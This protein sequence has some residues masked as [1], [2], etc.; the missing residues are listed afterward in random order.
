ME[1]SLLLKV[2][3]PLLGLG[4]ATTLLSSLFLAFIISSNAGGVITGII[5]LVLA[6]ALCFFAFFKNDNNRLKAILI[7]VVVFDLIGGFTAMS[8]EDKFHE[9]TGVLNKSMIHFI[10]LVGMMG[11]LCWFWHY[12]TAFMAAGHFDAAG[13]DLGQETMLY[14]CWSLLVAF[15]LA[16]ATGNK[17]SYYKDVLVKTCIVNSIGFWFLGA[18]LSGLLGLWIAFKSDSGDGGAVASPLNSASAVSEYDKI[19]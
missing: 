19:G 13:I 5:I 15:G 8:L 2:A 11:S 14:V 3:L 16:F 18:L 7:F 6:A 17:E 9:E 1:I 4:F 10:L 12:L